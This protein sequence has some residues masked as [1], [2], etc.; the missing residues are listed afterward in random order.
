MLRECISKSAATA[1]S[2][3]GFSGVMGSTTVLT[4]S[5]RSLAPQLQ[6]ISLRHRYRSSLAML[7]AAFWMIR[8][9]AS[10]RQRMG[11][12]RADLTARVCWAIINRALRV[13]PRTLYAGAMP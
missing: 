13:I 3:K 12:H 1:T 5:I 10:L 11:L 6:A 2:F 7:K 4:L 9:D 8:F